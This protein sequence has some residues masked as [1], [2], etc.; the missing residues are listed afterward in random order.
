MTYSILK[1]LPP[2][3][4]I[5]QEL[6]LPHSACQ[7]IAHDRQE[8]KAILEGRDKRLLMIV[9]LVRHGLK[10]RYWNT[11]SVWYNSTIKSNML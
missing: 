9:G 8:V 10:K 1:K 4:K 7:Q 11:R 6:P 2:I 5:I 3:E